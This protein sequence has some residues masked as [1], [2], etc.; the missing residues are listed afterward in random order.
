MHEF[1]LPG[2]SILNVGISLCNLFSLLASSWFEGTSFSGSH[3][4]DLGSQ[5]CL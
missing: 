2:G 1:G 4:A 5:T 3:I